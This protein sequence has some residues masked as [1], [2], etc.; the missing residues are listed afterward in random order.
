MRLPFALEH[1]RDG[2]C[3][4]RMTHSLSSL[5]CQK[6]KNFR[7]ALCWRVLRHSDAQFVISEGTGIP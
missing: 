3:N 1:R 6:F 5:V 4:K 7:N 2:Y